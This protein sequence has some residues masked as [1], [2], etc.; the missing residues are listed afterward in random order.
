MPALPFVSESEAEKLAFQNLEKFI[1]ECRCK[2]EN[3]VSKAIQKM[4]AVSLLA[5]DLVENGE[6][7]PLQ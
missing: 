2:N 4:I 7:T 3:D 6:K 1:N 5:I